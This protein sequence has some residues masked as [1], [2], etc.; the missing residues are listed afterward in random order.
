MT[1]GEKRT[2]RL[3]AV[4][5]VVLAVTG[6]LLYLP[7]LRGPLADSRPFLRAGHIIVGLAFAALLAANIPFFRQA[8]AGRDPVQSLLLAVAVAWLVTGGWLALGQYGWLAIPGDLS[9]AHLFLA[10]LGSAA[11]LF[12]AVRARC[13]P[14]PVA[15]AA[16]AVNGRR[17]FFIQAFGWFAALSLGAAWQWLL[18]AG[19][20]PPGDPAAF[21]DCNSLTPPPTPAPQSS[22]PVG[23]GYQG[24]FRVYTVAPIPCADSA[25]RFTVGGLVDKPRVYN[26]EEF[27]GLPR[28][29]QVSDFHCVEG[30]SVRRITYEGIPLAWLLDTAAVQPAAR[31]VKLLSGDGVYTDTLALDQA[32][33]NDVMV[34][35]LIDGRPIPSDL[36]GPAR[37]VVPQMY[38][39]KAVKWL[40]AIELINQPHSG[41]WE[42]RGY[43]ADAWVDKR[44]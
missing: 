35:L 12:H 15:E 38:A 18:P 41:Y 2:H 28:R 44:G 1:R 36:G 29:V 32:R 30:W 20:K 40:V 42:K 19:G 33:L 13:A 34:A 4:A 7:V 9:A 26:W 39:Y 43:P 22:P 8:A 23:G 3:L 25:W 24:K 6:F 14:R 27:V 16:D 11:A 31:Y 17:A 37:L 21:K 5:L 10:V